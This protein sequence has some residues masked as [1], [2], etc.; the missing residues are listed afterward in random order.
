MWVPALRVADDEPIAPEDDP[1]AALEALAEGTAPESPAR[2]RRLAR[3]ALLAVRDARRSA[4]IGIGLG[5]LGVLLALGMGALALSRDGGDQPARA[6]SE[7]DDIVAKARPGTVYIRARGVGQEASGTGV[8]IDAAEGLVLTNFHVIALGNDLQAGTPTRLDD[9]E[10]RAAAPCE[11]LAL[12]HVEG[13]EERRAIPLG[14]QSDIRQG[15]QVVALG[16]PASASGGRSL[17]STAGV[18]SAV[19]TPLRIPAPDQ[20]RFTNL[21]QTDAAL[22]PGNSG[23]PLVGPGGKLVGINTIL[24]AGSADQP[25]GDQGYAIGVDRIREVLSDFR[26]GRSRAWFGAGLLT[27]PPGILH[28]R[29]LPAGMLVTAAQEGTIAEKLRLEEVLLTAIDGKRVRSSL[30]SYCRAVGGVRSGD[31]LELTVFVGPGRKPQ[32]V[33]VEF[34]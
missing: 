27:P 22:G 13:L 20:P 32:T 23:G 9:A 14:R 26:D 30:A 3:A 33:R 6:V 11:D 24:F 7:T 12:L 34:D 1:E 10:V 16:Y 25:G 8:V 19:N 17:T 15:D 2:R 4:R 21:V 28:R 29:G 5:A 18:V 31:E